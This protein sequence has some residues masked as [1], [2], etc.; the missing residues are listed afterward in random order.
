MKGRVFPQDQLRETY[1]CCNGCEVYFWGFFNS[2]LV[3]MI[4]RG[5]IFATSLMLNP[6][7]WQVGSELAYDFQFSEA[8][9]AG[10]IVF[11]LKASHDCFLNHCNSSNACSGTEP[12][13]F[14]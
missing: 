6:S 2:T 5:S 12:R 4:V 3:Q 8:F 13:A 14:G 1:S 7:M 9:R 10:C 11:F